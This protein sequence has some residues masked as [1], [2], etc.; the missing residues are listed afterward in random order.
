MRSPNSASP[1]SASF[2]RAIAWR[3]R[4]PNPR[5]F[6]AES[7]VVDDLQPRHQR[8]ALKNDAAIGAGP[9][10]GSPSSSASPSVGGRKPASAESSVVLP[11]PEGAD[12]DDE[13]AAA[14]LEIDVREGDESP[15]RV[16]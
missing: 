11:Q 16:S 6:R 1:T 3:S 12:G 2:S 7:D 4:L 14:H 10:I 5:I 15:S 9:L 13:V 8:V